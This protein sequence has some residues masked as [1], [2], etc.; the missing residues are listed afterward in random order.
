MRSTFLF[1]LSIIFSLASCAKKGTLTGGPKDEDPPIFV[2]ASPEY[3]TTNFD[4]KKIKISF[5]EYIKL[6]KVNTQLVVSPPLEYSPE[7]SPAG[8][9]SKFINIKIQDTLKENTTYSF[10]FGNSVVDNAEGNVY[11]NFKY[12]F[13]TGDYIDSLE[14]SGSVKYAN[15]AEPANEVSILLY[16]LDSTFQDS[17]IYKSKGYYVGNTLDTTLYN[18]TNLKA[19]TYKMIAL[20]DQSSNYIYDPKED[21][22][23]FLESAIELPKDTANYELTLFKE[24]LP[25]RLITPKEINK[26]HIVIPFEGELP[27]D[28]KIKPQGNYVDLKYTLLKD[29]TKDSLNLWYPKDLKDSLMLKVT[30]LNEIDTFT[31]LFRTKKYDSLSIKNLN[32]GYIN[33]K[34]KFTLE[35]NQPIEKIDLEKI[36]LMY[37]D[38]TFKSPEIFYDSI[39]MQINFGIDLQESSKYELEILPGG[40]QSVFE[41]NID[42]L[43]YNIRTKKIEDYGEISLSFNSQEN[44]SIIIELLTE[45][46][47]LVSSFKGTSDDTVKF[48]L[49]TPKN[50]LIRV[51][52]DENKNGKWD[53]GNY[54]NNLQPEKII[55]FPRVINIRANFF[56]NETLELIP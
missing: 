32:K 20:K 23:G 36:S 52:L 27:Q 7:I 56:E 47:E 45:K 43:Q 42:T 1:A 10:N 12:V 39:K 13:S 3:M 16:P 40:I 35:S 51:I 14:V 38:S 44:Q 37:P 11:G 24:I 4:A 29:A 34:E 9:A 41:T 26:G 19:G 30:Y 55:Y 18:L 33:F 31:T 6:D 15:S 49:L 22:I 17:T 53:T 21:Q 48:D 46:E 50:Y 25:F 54:L 28:L 5:N 2:S 8:S